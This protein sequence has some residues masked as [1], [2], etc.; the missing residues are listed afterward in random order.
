M[1]SG[2]LACSGQ[3]H[4]RRAVCREITRV[5]I[6]RGLAF[7]VADLHTNTHTHNGV[8]VKTGQTKCQL[9]IHKKLCLVDNC[10]NSICV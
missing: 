4:K 9:N 10:G 1:T 6:G 7:G 5:Q 8:A 3:S 2:T